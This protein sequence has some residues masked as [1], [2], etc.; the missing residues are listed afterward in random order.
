MIGAV[1]LGAGFGRRF[2]SDKRLHPFKRN[3]DKT[4]TVAE[5]TL[6]KYTQVFDEVRV[7]IRPED[8]EL[9]EKLSA[10]PA[11]L[12]IAEEAHLGM[13]HSLAAGFSQLSWTWAF[14]ALL[15]MPFVKIATLTELKNAAGKSSQAGILR[16][17]LAPGYPESGA[18]GHPVGW[19]H[20]FF[21][22]IE[23]TQ[24]DAG[25][26]GLLREQ[27]RLITDIEVDDPG[28][29]RDIDTPADIPTSGVQT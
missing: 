1:I 20:S 27:S 19:H 14:V 29:V 12:V 18:S 22:A 23:T 17:V 24:G 21:P 9:T 3:L 2:G 26:R 7:V 13:G 8:V 28:I 15:D 5:A 4:V 6:A 10:F 16:P 25:A 11:T